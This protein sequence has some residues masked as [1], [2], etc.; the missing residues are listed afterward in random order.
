MKVDVVLGLQ[1][2]DEGKGKFVDVFAPG[3][4]IVARFQGG[5]NAGHT[6]E[7]DGK[8]HVLHTVPSG[9]F[10]DK[11]KNVIGNGVVVDPVIFQK[12]IE[13]IAQNFG[14][15]GVTLRDR[16]LISDKAK[17]ILPTHRL[18]DKAKEIS[19]GKH[20]IGSTL[21]GIGPTYQDD[22]GRIG[23][24]VGNIFDVD[25]LKKV[26]NLEKKHIKLITDM[27]LKNMSYSIGD[28][29]YD[30]YKKHWIES[31]EFLK[32][33]DITQTEYYI[34]ES[35][36]A[37]KKVLAEG[38]Q[39]TLLDIEFGTYPMVTSSNTIA[40]GVCTGLGIAPNRIGEVYG[41]FKPYLTRV[42]NGHFPTELY[43][44]GDESFQNL[45]GKLMAQHGREYGSTSGRPR[46]CGW[47]DLVALRYACMINGVTQLLVPKVDILS[48]DNGFDILKVATAYQ[49]SNG[50]EI[51]QFN[52][53]KL[54]E[55]SDII[56]KE[57]TAWPDLSDV[58]D[59]ISMPNELALYISWLES[60]LRI[61]ISM[62]STGPDREQILT[63]P[64]QCDTCD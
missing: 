37:G 36:D 46:R 59:L 41:V 29:S 24:R 17:L 38:A 23:I 3:Y 49:L 5:P 57:F 20:K 28:A 48:A 26:D 62:V 27:N 11:I 44:E 47:L 14:L 13:S 63:Y 55:I 6:L 22:K 18:L 15:A 58:K 4:D 8:K 54:D 61:P 31:I 39:G 35:L 16:L 40:G 21:R 52:I 34:N 33:F 60:H 50:R 53:N 45:F 2:G 1:W 19:K 43:H 25:F 7:F 64:E 32:T 51:T 10:R 42:G 9:I 56:Y 30:D 12:E